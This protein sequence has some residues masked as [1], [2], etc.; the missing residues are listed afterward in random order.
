MSTNGLFPF[1]LSTQMISLGRLIIYI[2][3]LVPSISMF[4]CQTAFWCTSSRYILE[5]IEP[6]VNCWWSRLDLSL[7]QDELLISQRHMTPRHHPLHLSF[8]L[9]PADISLST[10]RAAQKGFKSYEVWTWDGN[11]TDVHL[12][13]PER[14][15]WLD[16]WTWETERVWVSSPRALKASFLP[17][18]F[19][20]FTGVSQTRQWFKWSINNSQMWSN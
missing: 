3:F 5:R 16:A 6:W 4:T 7:P 20:S 17:S 9:S 14:R 1:K 15:V 18:V 8:P 12:L 13:P 19:C 10:H 2:L 11:H